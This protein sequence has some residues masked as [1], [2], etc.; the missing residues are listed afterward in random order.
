ML[1][2]QD[3]AKLSDEESATLNEVFNHLSDTTTIAKDE[4]GEWRWKRV[5]SNGECVGASTEGYKNKEDCVK[6]AR[7]NGCVV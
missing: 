1:T 4:K 7:R 2:S 6:N 3:F 5:C